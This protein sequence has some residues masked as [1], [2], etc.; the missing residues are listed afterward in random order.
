VATKTNKSP[1]KLAIGISFVLL[2]LMLIIG[3]DK[4]IDVLSSS[5]ENEPVKVESLNYEKKE[6]D[7]LP[8]RIIIP[9]LAIDLDVKESKVINGYWEVFDDSAGWGEG[10]GIP[11]KPG[12]QVIF[13]HARKGL[14]LPLRSLEI[15]DNI[16]V[17]SNGKYYSYKV[18]AISEVSPGQT[19]AIAPTDDETL[20]LYTCSGFA[21][22]KRLLVTL[23][24]SNTSV[25]KIEPGRVMMRYDGFCLFSC[26]LFLSQ[27][28]KQ[29]QGQADTLLNL[30]CY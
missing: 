1:K 2:G 26:S 8:E 5:F 17:L 23:Q 27:A 28:L 25:L 14:F 12:N 20:T 10:S 21:D 13:A 11:G 30:G 15:G 19:E 9:E 4:T 24:T 3:R 22:S 18:N 29:S 7:F 6:D 16:Y